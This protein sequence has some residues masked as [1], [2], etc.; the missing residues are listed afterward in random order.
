MP[1]IWVQ[2]AFAFVLF[3]LGLLVRRKTLRLGRR[4][5]WLQ[6]ADRVQTPVEEKPDSA[7]IQSGAYDLEEDQA[8]DPSI[9]L[10]LTAEAET[11]QRQPAQQVDEHRHRDSSFT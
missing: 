7:R 3:A 5:K 8:T 10:W 2:V 9:S 11:E 6:Y 1:P 4:L